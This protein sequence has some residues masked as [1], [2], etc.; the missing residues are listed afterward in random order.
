ML[1]VGFL[2]FSETS[3]DVKK[4]AN[5][6]AIRNFSLEPTIFAVQMLFTER[7]D[8]LGHL[9]IV[10]EF[11]CKLVRE[12]LDTVCCIHYAIWHSCIRR[13]RISNCNSDFNARKDTSIF[14]SF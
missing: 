12:C 7:H 4:R 8:L 10:S 9:F 11:Y 5:Q 6:P 13:Y 14:F 1:L 2:N 3:L